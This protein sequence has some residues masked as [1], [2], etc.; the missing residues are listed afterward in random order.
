MT[1][2]SIFGDT[3]SLAIVIDDVSSDTRATDWVILRYERKNYITV[4]RGGVIWRRRNLLPYVVI[5]RNSS[6]NICFWPGVE[7]DWIWLYFTFYLG[8]THRDTFAHIH[9]H[10]HT[11]R[12]Y[13]QTHTYMHTLFCLCFSCEDS[14]I[15]EFRRPSR[16]V[17][18]E[19]NP[20]TL[21]INCLIIWSQ[22]QLPCCLPPRGIFDAI[23][24]P[25]PF[26]YVFSVFIF[27]IYPPFF[28]LAAG[29]SEISTILGGKP[30]P[31][32]SL[33]QVLEDSGDLIVV[34]QRYK[35]PIYP[36]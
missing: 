31:W 23:K 7:L 16:S 8:H 1:T 18:K 28:A 4:S 11:R 20:Q 29:F 17:L 34:Y 26:L 15:W 10:T 33:C 22:T 6:E 32:K 30:N 5:S 21:R 12:T 24:V 25:W 19:A 27:E 3:C 35:D 13:K 2:P 36:T 9:T 14:R